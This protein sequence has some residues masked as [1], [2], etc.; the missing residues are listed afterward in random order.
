MN[1]EP[2]LSDTRIFATLDFLVDYYAHDGN[3]GEE[4]FQ[5]VISEGG[6][7]LVGSRIVEALPLSQGFQYFYILYDFSLPD[8]EK[9]IKRSQEK[10]TARVKIERDLT[11]LVRQVLKIPDYAGMVGYHVQ[12][13]VKDGEVCG[14]RAEP[15]S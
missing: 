8:A 5:C 7:S 1:K 15:K 10:G 2:F 13:I 9:T 12:L 11:G 14:F 3:L 6:Y 4:Q